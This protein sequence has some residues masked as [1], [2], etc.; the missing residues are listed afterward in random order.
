L[1]GSAPHT[2]NFA[3]RRD[4]LRLAEKLKLA[5]LL[6]LLVLWTTPATADDLIAKWLR[7]DESNGQVDIVRQDLNALTNEEWRDI[8]DIGSKQPDAELGRLLLERAAATPTHVFSAWLAAL[9]AAFAMMIGGIKARTYL[10]RELRTLTV[11]LHMK[12]PS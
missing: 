4:R 10:R 7:Q 9:A 3:V 6:A 12:D 2:P 11:P 8:F 5:A 1:V